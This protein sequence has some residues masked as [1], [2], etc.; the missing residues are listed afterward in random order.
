[1][2]DAVLEAPGEVSLGGNG[3]EVARENDERY[4]GAPATEEEDV[5]VVVQHR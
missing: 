3:V 1:V 2:D 5:A 4:S